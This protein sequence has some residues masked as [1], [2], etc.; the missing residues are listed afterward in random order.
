MAK[1]RSKY[2]GSK[3]DKF[4]KAEKP[5]KLTV[6]QTWMAMPLV[7]RI[8][9]FSGISVMIFGLYGL[10]QP[11]TPV[12]VYFSTQM[13]LGIM[14]GSMGYREMKRETGRKNY[15]LFYGAAVLC[16]VFSLNYYLKL[17]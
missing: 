14:F 9:L 16:V 12:W 3:P 6:L 1:P 11:V 7:A 17:F 4:F 8:T 15:I 13:L 10:S 5:R 2:K